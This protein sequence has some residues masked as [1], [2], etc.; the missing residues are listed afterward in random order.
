[1]DE[2]GAAQLEKYEG[3]DN[4]LVMREQRINAAIWAISEYRRV[5]ADAALMA[6]VRAW[7]RGK[8]DELASV[9]DDL[10]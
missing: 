10:G 7:I 5:T 4:A 6:D 8:R 1:M 9:L 3:L 2:C